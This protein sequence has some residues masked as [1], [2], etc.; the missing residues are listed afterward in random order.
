MTKQDDPIK[1]RPPPTPP[2]QTDKEW[3]IDI[4]PSKRGGN[5]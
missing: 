4:D 5:K 3:I 1:H 2:P